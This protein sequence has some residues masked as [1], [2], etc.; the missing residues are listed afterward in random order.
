[1]K[2]SNINDQHGIL[3]QSHLEYDGKIILK[4]MIGYSYAN[5]SGRGV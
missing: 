4:E 2:V 1:V 3:T 5:H